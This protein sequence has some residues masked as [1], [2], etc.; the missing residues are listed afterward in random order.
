MGALVAVGGLGA[1][2]VLF[3]GAVTTSVARTVVKP[4]RRRVEDTRIIRYDE[5][6]S[7][8]QLGITADSVMPG[9]YSFWFSSGTGHA[10]VGE[11]ISRSPASVTRR[12]IAVD[13]GELNDAHHGRFNGWVYL[14]PRELEVPYE[15]VRVQTTLGPAPAWLVRAADERSDLWV[16][17]VH[18]RATVRQETLRAVPVFR[19]AGYNS[20]LISYRNDGEA[21]ASEDH[22]YSLGDVEWLDV[23]AAMLYALDH[24]ATKIVLM[25]WSMGGATVLQAATRSRL[26]S[27]VDGIVLDSPVVNWVDTLMY[28]GEAMSLPGPV[29]KGILAMISKPWGRVLTGQAESIDLARLD[30][31]RRADELD[32]PI[33]LLHSDDDGY[34]PSSGSRELAAARPD[35]VTFVPFETARHTKLW[36]YD[37]GRWNGVVAD[38]LARRSV[39]AAR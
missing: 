17:Q 4:P 9:E 14:S 38:W 28:Q 25:G 24:G 20:L 34:V 10:R 22:R 12:V 26:A 36:N 6:A 3:A 5:G 2:G 39:T 7:T 8:I 13:Y 16:I 35:I 32:V 23:E 29:K 33:L 30:F 1:A 11:V 19:E 27:V 18:G 31:V 15:S 37:R 21:P